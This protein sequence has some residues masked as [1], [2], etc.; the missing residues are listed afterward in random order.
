MTTST[1]NIRMDIDLKKE[2]DEVSKGIGLSSAAAFNVFARQFVAY[3]GFPFEVKMP[4]F[5]EKEFAEEMD[6]I[7]LSMKDGNALEHRLIEG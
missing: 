1:F 6:S 7:Y 3:R 4:S 2:V 5:T